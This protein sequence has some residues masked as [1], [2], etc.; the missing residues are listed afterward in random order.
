MAVALGAAVRLWMIDQDE[1]VYWNDSAD[2]VASGT[3]GWL[4]L[5]R[6]AGP[7]PVLATTVLGVLDGDLERFVLAQVAVAALC[8]GVLA[9]TVAWAMGGRVRPVVGAGAVVALSLCWPVAMWDQEVLTEST[10]LSA[11]ALVGAALIAFARRP[12]RRAGAALL[13]SGALFLAARDTHVVP[14]AVGAVAMAVAAVRWRSLRTRTWF[15]TAALLAALCFL[16]AGS[17]QHGGRGEVPMEHTYAARVLPDAE[18]VAW[19]AEHGMPQADE[20]EAIPEVIDPTGERAPFT[21]LAPDPRWDPWRRWLRAEGRSTLLRYV[22]AHPTYVVREPRRSPE[23]VFNNGEGVATYRPLALRE[24]PLV[25]AIFWP[26]TSV[27]VVLAGAAA[28]TVIVVGGRWAGLGAAG[29]VAV[30]TAAPHA[31]VVWHGDGMESARHLLVPA[32]QLRLGAL[33]LVLAAVDAV[34]YRYWP[35]A[36]RSIERPPSGSRSPSLLMRVRM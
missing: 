23:R 18:R 20:L 21:P 2:Y 5:E 27:A 10:A 30:L 28:I 4:T 33:L 7:R 13:A 29:A 9:G 32:V 16:V 36:T 6:W 3:T 17:S 1:P 34:A 24:V 25:D 8:W 14:I 19:F 35:V 11:L 22:L 12:D 15:A 31:L 26:P